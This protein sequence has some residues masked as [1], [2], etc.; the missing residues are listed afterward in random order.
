[1]NDNK[2]INEYFNKPINTNSPIR[3]SLSSA[4]GGVVN[5][6]AGSKSPSPSQLASSYQ[7]QQMFPPSPQN[8]QS[9]VVTTAPGTPTPGVGE[10]H[11]ARKN[12][13][14]SI[15]PTTAAAATT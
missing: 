1:M 13:V 6:S 12:S 5:N 2:K 10:F 11:Y 3:P 4:G 7:Q 8:Q 14:R 9:N 15:P